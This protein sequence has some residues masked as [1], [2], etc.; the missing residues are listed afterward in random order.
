MYVINNQLLCIN[1]ITTNIPYYDQLRLFA[2]DCLAAAGRDHQILQSSLDTLTTWT[3]IWQMYFTVSA[4]K[5]LQ[6]YSSY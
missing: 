3:R 1:D 5:I 6:V 2:D 4:F